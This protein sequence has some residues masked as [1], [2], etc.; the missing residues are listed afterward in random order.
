MDLQVA[1]ALTSYVYQSALAQNGNVNQALA[2]AMAVSQAQAS[3]ASNL[4][5]T[6]ASADPFASLLGGVANTELTALSF[7]TAVP[8]GT[9]P[10]SV[11]ALLASMG[12]NPATLFSGA[13]SLPASAALLSP[14]SVQ[15]L[16]RF[17]YGQSPD[18]ATTTQQ[19]L[20]SAQQTMLGFGLNLWA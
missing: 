11:Q 3:N 18:A 5:A 15:A 1:G 10:E 7:D 8:P 16:V 2:K 13:D 12:S 20:F 19:A 14:A 9:G 17:A 4:L 6:T